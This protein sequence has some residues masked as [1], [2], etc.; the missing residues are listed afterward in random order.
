MACTGCDVSL[1]KT[2]ARALVPE[3]KAPVR[4]SHSG[5]RAGDSPASSVVHHDGTAMNQPMTEL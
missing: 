3:S 2:G 4:G 1:P 5:H